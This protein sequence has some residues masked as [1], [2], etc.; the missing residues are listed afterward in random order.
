MNHG[1][2][3]S[4]LINLLIN[5]GKNSCFEG[6]SLANKQL[7]ITFKVYVKMLTCS[8]TTKFIVPSLRQT[9]LLQ[10]V[11]CIHGELYAFSQYSH[12]VTF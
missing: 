7:P 1:C 5:M 6:L 4:L 2:L 11:V 9:G 10:I 8:L 3:I 12:R